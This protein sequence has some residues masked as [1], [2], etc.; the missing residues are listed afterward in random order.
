M[1]AWCSDLSA[2]PQAN[3]KHVVR[4]GAAAPRQ[5]LLLVFI[6]QRQD[7]CMLCCALRLA[8]QTSASLLFFTLCLLA[9]TGDPVDAS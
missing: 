2:W 8:A 6:G 5:S 3:R 7:A 1:N 9:G 4:T